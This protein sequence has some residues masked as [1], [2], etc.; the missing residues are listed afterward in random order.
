MQLELGASANEREGS[1]VICGV[2]VGSWGLGVQD[3]GFEGLG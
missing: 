1:G 2:R 3:L